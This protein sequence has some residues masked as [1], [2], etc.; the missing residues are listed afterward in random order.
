[1][2]KQSKSSEPSFVSS[3][4]VCAAVAVFL[5]VLMFCLVERPDAW[6]DGHTL[7]NFLLSA[8]MVVFPVAFVLILGSCFQ[9]SVDDRKVSDYGQAHE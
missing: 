7:E 6:R 2:T 4:P 8:F 9:S 1:M 5:M 3:I